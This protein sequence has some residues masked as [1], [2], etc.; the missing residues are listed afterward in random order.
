MNTSTV[1]V[2]IDVAKETLD[3][4]LLPA[5][6]HWT[7][8]NNEAEVA[9][10]AK[11]L[12]AL[13]ADTLVVLEATNVFWQ[14]AATVLASAGLRVAVVNPRQVRNFAKALGVLAKTDRIDAEVLALFAER[15]R[16]PARP[17]PDAQCQ[18][19]AELLSRRAQLMGMRVAEKNRLAT[20][21]AKQVR[22][23]IET[24]LSFLE[25]R[26][27]AMDEELDQWLKTTPIDQ[28]RLNLLTSFAGIGPQTARTLA[29][30]LPELG[31][32]TGRQISALVGVAPMNDDSG[33]HQ[34]QR[35]IRGGRSMVRTSL[36]MPT[37][38][39]IRCN[40]VIAQF[41]QRLVKAGKHH[42][43]AIT[44]CM[45]KILIILNAMLKS[46]QPWTPQHHLT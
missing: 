32:L 28:T 22:K 34:G 30:A 35:H 39:A 38:T 4:H 9:E 12:C 7:L 19:A 43:V 13:K 45:R 1:F 16:P 11:R 14:V 23:D 18:V 6:E 10:L 29:I 44:A 33:K 8:L 31:S 26:L 41:Y 40:P 46:G 25:K 5:G 17:L 3:V 2:G 24:T 15:I 37:L 42:Y 36:Y 21:R 27:H 20:A